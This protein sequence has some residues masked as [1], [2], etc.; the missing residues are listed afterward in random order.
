MEIKVLKVMKETMKVKHAIGEQIC[1]D[2]AEEKQIDEDE[3]EKTA[4][5]AA[6]AAE[7]EANAF[8]GIGIP[9]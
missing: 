8:Y 6:E 5:E 1:A 2:A 9:M 3:E 4:R 7:K